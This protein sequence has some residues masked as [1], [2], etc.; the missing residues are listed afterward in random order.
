MSTAAQ[1]Q[2]RIRGKGKGKEMLVRF[3]GEVVVG[4][5]EGG[6]REE[7]V[8]VRDPRKIGGL[9]KGQ[10]LRPGRAEFYELKYE[11]SFLFHF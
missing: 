3:E 1:S 8:V 2:E 9:K 10:I 7:E 11:V 6:M 5:G 4:V